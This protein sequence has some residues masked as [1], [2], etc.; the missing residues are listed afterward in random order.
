MRPRLTLFEFGHAARNQERVSFVIKCWRSSGILCV[1]VR[2]EHDLPLPRP[3]QQD[4]IRV[5]EHFRSMAGIGPVAD[6]QL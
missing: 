4:T 6:R 3:R 2:H 5:Q 1:A